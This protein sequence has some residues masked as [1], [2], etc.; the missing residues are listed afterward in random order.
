MTAD[1]SRLVS[2]QMRK[3]LWYNADGASMGELLSKTPRGAAMKAASRGEE[4]A[5]IVLHDSDTDQLHIFRGHRTEITEDQQTAYTRR[6]GI[7]FKP[8]VSKL[9]YDKSGCGRQIADRIAD[10]ITHN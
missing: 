10:I 4:A 3:Y 1:L 5:I 6:H 7:K 8:N 2:K 9:A